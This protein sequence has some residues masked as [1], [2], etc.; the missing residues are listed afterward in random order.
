MRFHDRRDAGRQ[1][2]ALVRELDLQQPI[3]LAL[4]RGGVPVAFE[5]AL[6]LG[7]PLDVLVARKIGAPQQPELGIG[8]LAE[9]G[10]RVVDP[11]LVRALR[12]SE[13]AV[14]QLAAREQDELERRVHAYRGD[15]HLPSLEGRDVVLVD[16][17]VATG[18][19]AEASLLAIGRQ[20][21]S[22]L[23]LAVP[24]CAP[25]AKARLQ[26]VADEVVSVITPT[27]LT[28]VGQWYRDFTQTT[29]A[30]VLDLLAAAAEAV[31]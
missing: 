5:V 20:H 9:G 14:E 11:D 22:R 15:R 28:A 31:R 27:D 12:L 25:D 6:A 13:G 10:A 7:A 16:D 2:A 23:V 3:V 21:P 18:G 1:L 8:A 26:A 30:E 29:D 24:T 4:P 17:G 19:T